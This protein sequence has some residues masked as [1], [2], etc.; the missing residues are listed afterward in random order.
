[1]SLAARL[2]RTAQGSVSKFSAA[3]A[4]GARFE[5]TGFRRTSIILD[6]QFN[7][8]LHEFVRQ[9]LGGTIAHRTFRQDLLAI[10]ISVATDMWEA[11]ITARTAM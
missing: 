3:T 9:T 4:E 2:N 1:M 8:V 10:R 5:S 11:N 6:R 7:E